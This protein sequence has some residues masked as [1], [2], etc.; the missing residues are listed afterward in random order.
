LQLRN[1]FLIGIRCLIIIL[2][3]TSPIVAEAQAKTAKLRH[4]VAIKFKSTTTEKQ[5]QEVENAFQSLKRK[6]HQVESIEGGTNV[7]P[8]K[9]SQGFTHGFLVTFKSEKDRDA[10]L[11]DPAHLKFKELALPLVDSVFI[12]DFWGKS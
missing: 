1:I 8:E 5:I 4:F 7:S 10:Y 6:I 2:F 12:I 3:L 11:I 9:R